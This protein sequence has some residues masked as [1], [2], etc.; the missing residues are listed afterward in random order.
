MSRDVVAFLG[1]FATSPGLRGFE[2]AL[3]S[4]ALGAIVAVPGVLSLLA[5]ADRPALMLPAAM[6]LFPLS[7][8]SMAGV[9]LP[10]MIA[11][12][13]LFVSFGRRSVGQMS[14]DGRVALTIL[15]VMVLMVAAVAALLVHE[16]PRTYTTPTGGGS[17][18][19]VV[20]II[21]S[22]ISL[23]LAAA[24]VGSGW[25]LAPASTVS[26][27]RSCRARTSPRAR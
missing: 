10:L 6:L 12:A 20:T 23:A 16:D 7:F 22:L 26:P 15:T 1:Y 9:L 13:M 24:A 2:A 4:V 3:A 11:A 25:L 27:G 14:S 17:T 5:V 19:D 18:S 21:E 8:R